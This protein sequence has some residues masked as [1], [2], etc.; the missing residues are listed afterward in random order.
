MNPQPLC[1]RGRLESDMTTAG[2]LAGPAV[3]PS[4]GKLTD[5]PAGGWV[6]SSTYLALKEG[7]TAQ[8]RLFELMGPIQEALAVQPGLLAIELRSSMSW[9]TAR[10]FS[11]WEPRSEAR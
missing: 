3:D 8:T 6:V 4:T 9:G 11:V 1:E 7:Q 2:P 10:T 5:P